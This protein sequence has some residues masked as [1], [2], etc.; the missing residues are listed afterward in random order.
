VQKLA[1][2]NRMPGGS[3][4]AFARLLPGVTGTLGGIL[5]QGANALYSGANRRLQERLTRGLLDPV[6][7][8]SLLEAAQPAGVPPVMGLLGQVRKQGEKVLPLA[9]RTAPLL[10]TQ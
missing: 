9:Y 10:M 7:A 8:L 2:A 5:S 1:T 6:E 4:G 3:P